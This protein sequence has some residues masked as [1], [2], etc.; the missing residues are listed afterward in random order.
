VGLLLAHVLAVEDD[1]AGR[2][3]KDPGDGLEQ[4]RLAGSVRAQHTDDLPGLDPDADSMQHRDASVA[5]LD[6]RDL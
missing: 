6:I 2:E 4:R 5:G 1:L 3:G